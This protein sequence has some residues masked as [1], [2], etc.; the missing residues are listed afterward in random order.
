M[1]LNYVLLNLVIADH[2][3]GRGT[4][5]FKVV[6]TTWKAKSHVFQP[7]KANPSVDRGPVNLNIFRTD[8][9]LEF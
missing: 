5:F 1:L 4:L 9:D 6:D 2:L 8:L 3:V 7:S